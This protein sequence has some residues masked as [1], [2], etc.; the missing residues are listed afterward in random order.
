MLPERRDKILMSIKKSRWM[1]DKI[2]KM[3]HDGV[4]CADIAQQINATMWLLKSANMALLENHL[5]TCWI[6]KIQSGDPGAIADFSEEIMK[7]WNLTQRS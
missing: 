7:V 6:K 1:L 4:Y 2:E 5:Q 3:L